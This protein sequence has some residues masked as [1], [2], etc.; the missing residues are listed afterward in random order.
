MYFI[1]Q[2]LGNNI[3][4]FT[5]NSC[6]DFIDFT[7]LCFYHHLCNYCNRV[8]SDQSSN[9]AVCKMLNTTDNKLKKD[10]V[11][12]INSVHVEPICHSLEPCATALTTAQWYCTRLKKISDA[13]KLFSY[14]WE[15]LFYFFSS[16]IET[17]SQQ[18]KQSSDKL[19]IPCGIKY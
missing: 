1:S 15:D 8:F 17:S 16:K 5:F 2:L 4:A 14:E 3:L 10:F 11:L 18:N 19:E 7:F 9:V 13:L 6:I 12:K